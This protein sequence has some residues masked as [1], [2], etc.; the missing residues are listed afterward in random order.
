MADAHSRIGRAAR[1]GWASST[2]PRTRR[3]HGVRAEI[4]LGPTRWWRWSGALDNDFQGTVPA[5]C[6][7][8]SFWRV[9]LSGNLFEDAAGRG[10][11]HGLRPPVPQDLR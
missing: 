7:T 6:A 9:E 2:S 3:I 4:D 8:S 10:L 5:S 1:G 11:L